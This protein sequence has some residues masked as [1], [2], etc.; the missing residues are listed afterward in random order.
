MCGPHKVVTH[1]DWYVTK[2][3]THTN[4]MENAWSLFARSV[5]GAFHKIS[6]KH[7]QCY[8]REFDSRFNARNENGAYFPRLLNQSIGRRLP[9]KELVNGKATA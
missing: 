6:V 5:M 3:G 9:M 7:L 8:L 1:A 2:D 4:G